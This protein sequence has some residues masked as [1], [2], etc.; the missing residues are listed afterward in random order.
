MS[1]GFDLLVSLGTRN[2]STLSEIA[3]ELGIPVNA[4]QGWIDLLC[5]TGYLERS[6]SEDHPCSCSSCPAG[7]SCVSCRCASSRLPSPDTRFELTDRGREYVR[8]TMSTPPI[9]SFS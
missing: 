6:G 4:V 2:T 1:N 3:M 7:T 9:S 8:R 5:C